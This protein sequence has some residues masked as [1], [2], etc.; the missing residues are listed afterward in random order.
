MQLIDADVSNA[1]LG[2][3]KLVPA[4]RH[5]FQANITVPLRHTHT[6]ECDGRKGIT[7][8]MPAWD[9]KK[10]FGL[11]TVN[12]F[13]ANHE[14]DLPGLHSTYLLYDG[15][16]GKPLAHVDGDAVTSRRTAAA[17]ALAGG[18]L[19]KKDASRLFVLGTGRV[20]SF[21]P[22]AY[23]VV[24]PIKDVFVWNRRP[25]GAER[26]VQ[27]LNEKGYN[28]HVVST[29]EEGVA[30]ADIISCA[31]LSE[32]PL[33]HGEWLKPGQHLDLIGSFAPHMIETDAQC[34]AR[35]AVFVDTDEAAKKAGDLLQAIEAGTLTVEA[36][37]AT[38]FDLCKGEH[39]GRTSDDQITVF[40]S[41][42]NALE[43][44]TAAILVYEGSQQT[45]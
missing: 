36:I 20:A 13:S 38:L 10:Y 11:K 1:L 6:I 18:Y 42:G 24:R 9:N 19:A 32:A 25:E 33:V 31:T 15:R 26:L 39:A 35:A 45:A 5:A 34:F 41:V 17:S 28:A 30:Q 3:D 43:D 22:D 7:L 8:I 44:L 12:I 37:Q 2:F 16:T 23:S 21:L 27:E 4:L 40:K 29:V 14:L